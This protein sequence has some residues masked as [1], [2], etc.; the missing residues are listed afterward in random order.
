MNFMFLKKPQ[1]E[2]LLVFMT[3]CIYI[4]IY[5][6]AIICNHCFSFS[7]T[8][9]ARLLRSSLLVVYAPFALW[10]CKPFTRNHN[11]NTTDDIIRCEK[12]IVNTYSKLGIGVCMCMLVCVW[13]LFI[14]LTTCGKKLSLKGVACD[15]MLR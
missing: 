12:K 2:D 15:L 6:Q 4:N 14:I 7:F 8:P 5:S 10:Q 1:K 3:Q 11:K 9:E 13:V